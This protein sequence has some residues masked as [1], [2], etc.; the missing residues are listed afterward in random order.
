MMT[1][2]LLKHNYKNPLYRAWS[3]MKTRC[4]NPCEHDKKYYK[5]KGIKVAPEW[6]DS[7]DCFAEWAVSNGYSVGLT[8]DRIDGNKGYSPDNCRWI[9]LAEQQR[10]KSNN[11]FYTYN[12]KTQVLSVW[13]KE[14]GIDF[15]TLSDRL[16]KFNF[17][18]EEAL[19]RPV[20]RP[21]NTK[22]FQYN[23]KFYTTGELALMCGIK[24]QALR[25]RLRRGW[26]VEK[27]ISTPLM[28]ASDRTLRVEVEE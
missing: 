3:N 16:S 9:T 1:N 25:S 23:G 13:A 21:R 8:I 24:K 26:S 18:F 28:S 14:Y 19:T 22:L 5:K 10:N 6:E 27:A 20:R 12:G 17:T 4:N 11:R 2:S 7:F 15:K